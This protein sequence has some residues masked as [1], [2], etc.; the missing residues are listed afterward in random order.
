MTLFEL[1]HTAVDKGLHESLVWH[2]LVCRHGLRPLDQVQ[3]E[4]E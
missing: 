4:P 3:W 1:P 2:L